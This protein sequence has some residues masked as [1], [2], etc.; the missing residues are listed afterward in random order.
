MW[1]LDM[2]YIAISGILPQSQ[3]RTAFDKAHCEYS[4]LLL[5]GDLW[6]VIHKSGQGAIYCTTRI[7]VNLLKVIRGLLKNDG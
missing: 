3:E 7:S 1:L 6:T 5:D 4:F 2:R